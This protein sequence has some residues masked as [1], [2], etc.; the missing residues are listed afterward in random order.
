MSLLATVALA[1][2]WGAFALTWL[3]GAI[4]YQSRARTG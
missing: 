3:I 1:T 4:Y 2:C